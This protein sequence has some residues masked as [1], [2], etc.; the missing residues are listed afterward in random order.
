MRTNQLF[1]NSLLIILITIRSLFS[2]N[3]TSAEYVEAAWSAWN[4]NDQKTVEQKFRQAITVDPSNTRAYVGLSYLYEMQ[5]KYLEAWQNY[6]KVVKTESDFESYIF[7][8]MMTPRLT[9]AEEDKS[10]GIPALFDHLSRH[11]RHSTM[12]VN[13]DEK[14]GRFYNEHAN[15]KKALVYFDK[16]DAI[17]DWMLI[18]PFDNIS[19]SGYD[20][21]YAPETAFDTAAV[22]QGQNDV[23]I[24]WFRIPAIRYDKWV[25]MRRYFAN[26]NAV[27]YGNTFIY[28]SQKQTIQLRVGTS[29]SLKVF[30]ND[31]LMIEYFDENNNG[32]DTYSVE[33]ELQAGWNRLLIKCGYS[34][35]T[36]CNFA[37][38]LT[39]QQGNSIPDLRISALPQSY[40]SHPGADKKSIPN[41]AEEFF[42]D[43]IKTHPDHLENYLLLAECY[44]LNDKAIESELILREALRRA[45]QNAMIYLHLIEAYLRGEKYDEA[46]SAY[47]KIYQL[48][49]DIPAV[50]ERRISDLLEKQNY[51]EAKNLLDRLAQLIPESPDLQSQFIVYYSKRDLTEKVLEVV[52]TAY[53]K[54]PEV[55]DIVETKATIEAYVKQNY[56]AGIPILRKYVKKHTDQTA[57]LKLAEYYQKASDLKG[58]E[59][60][61]QQALKYY[62]AAPGLYYQMA[63]N[64]YNMHDYFRAADYIEEALQICPQC[65]VYWGTRAEIQRS[66][67]QKTPAIQ[68]YRRALELSPTYYEARDNL[69]Q[70]LD[71]QSIFNNFDTVNIDSLYNNSPSPE[72]YPGEKALIL[73]NARQR[74]VYGGATELCQEILTIVF[75]L[76]GIDTFKEYWIPYN[77]YNEELI[78]EGADSQKKWLENRCRR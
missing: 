66:A 10:A 35:I 7:A 50:L 71:R 22:C 24:K 40:K 74:I 2:E 59:K 51:D 8:A 75:N 28:S 34:E 76:D 67:G 68:S 27:F 47:E 36:Q 44:A 77:G 9:N 12:R 73:Y 19:A 18:G 21:S 58:W 64:Y 17:T 60:A 63:R 13:A 33:T 30:L 69:R 4:E 72:Q 41:F 78:V 39:D 52:N 55:W 3:P 46:N 61:Y 6:A 26:D 62:P 5:Y 56:K 49:P 32:H 65:A 1:R 20:K 43:K 29:G 16:I 37:V 45:P 57:L 38:R 53:R 14:L 48:D 15:L 25:D 23:A 11:A 31:E 54:F 42:L 70:L